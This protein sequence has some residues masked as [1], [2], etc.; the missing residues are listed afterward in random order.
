MFD[1]PRGRLVGVQICG[2]EHVDVSKCLELQ[3]IVARVSHK[4]RGLFATLAFKPNVGRNHKIDA[5]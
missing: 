2:E 4:H 5:V 3:M 1:P